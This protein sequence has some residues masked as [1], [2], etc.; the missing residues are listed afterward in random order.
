MVGA[1][2]G[3]ARGGALAPAVADLALRL[4][5]RA[6]RR[7]VVG[8]GLASGAERLSEMVLSAV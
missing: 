3:L 5:A 7:G 6:D 1:A 8:S 2:L 4:L